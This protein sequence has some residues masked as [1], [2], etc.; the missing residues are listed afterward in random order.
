MASYKTKYFGELTIDEE[1]D[2]IDVTFKNSEINLFFSDVALYGEK[3]K[4][5]VEILDRYEEIDN[6]ARKAIVENYASDET[7]SYYFES[8]FED[9]DEETLIETF[10]V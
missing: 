5:V 7:I 8:Y 2:Y 1:N 9:F 6:A 10:G 3:I 4:T